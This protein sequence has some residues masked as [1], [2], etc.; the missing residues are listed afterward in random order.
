MPEHAMFEIGEAA[1][2]VEAHVLHLPGGEMIT[3][4]PIQP[5]DAERLQAYVRDLSVETR[6]NRF[7]GALSELAPTQL[8]RLTHMCSAGEL[9]LLVFADAGGTTHLVGE[10]VMVTF[11]AIAA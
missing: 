10:A 6:R 1:W 3:V 9:A 11:A 7:L 8:N 4:R 5:Q 2:S